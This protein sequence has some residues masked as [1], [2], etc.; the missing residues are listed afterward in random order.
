MISFIFSTVAKTAKFV[1]GLAAVAK[2]QQVVEYDEGM[3][4]AEIEIDTLLRL[5]EQR[6]A[7]PK[8][9]IRWLRTIIA[10]ERRRQEIKWIRTELER[11][12]LWKPPL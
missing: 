8:A 3:H 10:K 11:A 7:D 9:G 5:I 4:D 1:K 2:N 6:F 12:S